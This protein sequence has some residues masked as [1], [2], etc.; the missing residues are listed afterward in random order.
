M[1]GVATLLVLC[2]FFI[3]ATQAGNC[4][5][6]T[7][8]NKCGSIS[9]CCK[10]NG[11]GICDPICCFGSCINSAGCPVM[12]GKDCSCTNSVCV[13]SSDVSETIAT[14][15]LK[16]QSIPSQGNIAA[17]AGPML[18]PQWNSTIISETGK[19]AV[20]SAN[21]HKMYSFIKAELAHSKY[22]ILACNHNTSEPN[23]FCYH[24][25]EG[26]C[27]ALPLRPYLQQHPLKFPS[28]QGKVTIHGKELDH[29]RGEWYIGQNVNANYYGSV[30][31]DYSIPVLVI[32]EGGQTLD[33]EDFTMTSDIPTPGCN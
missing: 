15:D 19:A 9:S 27:Q 24:T 26:H 8:C 32:L 3:R 20:F 13:A 29:W 7:E 18:P 21:Y 28:Y 10:C 6:A 22:E 11:I 23:H 1:R 17:P 25:F 33:F 5:I 16:I 14:R 31:N 4:G 2:F 30:E 12:F